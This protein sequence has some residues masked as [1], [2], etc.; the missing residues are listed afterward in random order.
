MTVIERVSYIHLDGRDK[1]K[2]EQGSVRRYSDDHLQG[3]SIVHV[4]PFAQLTEVWVEGYESV[5]RSEVQG[6]VNAP[7][8]LRQN[9]IS[10]ESFQGIRTTRTSRTFLAGWNNP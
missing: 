9:R 6:V 1:G 7:V 8:H 10:Q 5:L 3:V 4:L 2:R